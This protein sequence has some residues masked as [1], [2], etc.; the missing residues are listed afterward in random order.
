[1]SVAYEHL[2]DEWF[3]VCRWL[4]QFG[5]EYADAVANT[6]GIALGALTWKYPTLFDLI[7]FRLAY[8]PTNDLDNETRSSNSWLYGQIYYLDIRGHGEPASES[9]VD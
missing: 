6:L 5:F 1:M 8:V 7:S 4:Y 9:R 2:G 3:R